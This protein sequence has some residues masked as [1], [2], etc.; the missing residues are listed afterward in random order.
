MLHP[1]TTHDRS[2][3]D[4]SYALLDYL[5]Q[6]MIGLTDD[7]RHGAEN[8][9]LGALIALACDALEDDEQISAAIDGARDDAEGRR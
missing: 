5:D 6:Q 4:R 3:R 8:H 1:R 7:Q 9:L 2:T